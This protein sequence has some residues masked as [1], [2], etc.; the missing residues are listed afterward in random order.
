MV[1]NRRCPNQR[2]SVDIY[3]KYMQWRQ[4]FCTERIEN[5]IS[6]VNK[7]WLN[8][9]NIF[10]VST[11]ANSENKY[12]RANEDMLLEIESFRKQWKVEAVEC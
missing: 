10:L 5:N 6:G 3:K 2:K 1:I 7:A 11:I 4:V 9:G 8:I 12:T